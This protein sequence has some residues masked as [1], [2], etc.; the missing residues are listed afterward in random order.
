MLE[1]GTTIYEILR[2]VRPLVLNSA[3]VVEESLRADGV[4]VGMRAVLEMLAERGP[5]TVP[6][7]ADRL[8]LARQGIQRHVNDLTALGWVESHDN[9][10]HRRS[11]LIAVTAAGAELFARVRAGELSRLDRMAAECTS[12]EFAATLKVLA[13]LSRDIRAEVRS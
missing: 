10:A 1:R 5:M 7:I 3:R 9:P 11:V 2:H 6:D 4:S 8:D 13:A 12:E